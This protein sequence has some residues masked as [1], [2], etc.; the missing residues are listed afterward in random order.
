MIKVLHKAL[1]ILEYLGSHPDGDTLSAI[2]AH[3]GEKPTTTSNIVQVL[4]GRN[5][6]ERVDGRWKL[7]VSTYLLTGSMLDY[8]RALTGIAQ[9]ILNVLAA[10]TEASAVLS[11]WRQNERYVLLRSADPSAVTVNRA[12]PEATEVYRTAT[13]MMLLACQSD[14]VIG[15]YIA[16]H[17]V[18][19]LESP[20]EN[21]VA[22]FRAVL[23]LCRERGYYVREKESIYEAAAPIRDPDGQMRT[24]VGIFL[25]LF[26]V[27][28]KNALIASLLDATGRL[29]RGLAA[30]R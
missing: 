26:R 30:R 7:G 13:G 6:L 1:N 28:D 14:E 20:S 11:V 9:P 16:A 15:D 25:P 21:A 2:A 4:A 29:E 8:D 18:P 23:S 19:G 5:Y 10:E 17:G 3:I 27:K 12:Y 22:S 24:A